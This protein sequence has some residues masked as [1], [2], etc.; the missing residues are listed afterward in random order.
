MQH[1]N[2]VVKNNCH[3]QEPVPQGC[4]AGNISGIYNACRYHKKG[5]SLLNRCVEDPRLQISG[6]TPNWITARGFTLIELLVVVLIMGILAAV[7]VPQYQKA[8]LAARYKNLLATFQPITQSMERYYL[9]SGTYPSSLSQLDVQVPGKMGGGEGTSSDSRNLNGYCINLYPSSGWYW[10][11][12]RKCPGSR[13]ENGYVYIPKQTRRFY[14]VDP[15]LYCFQSYA[16][17]NKHDGGC[18]GRLVNQSTY[19]YFYTLN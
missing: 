11:T 13:G 12:F 2:V 1:R 6:M 18:K 7:A 4:C 5:Q 9:E 17:I 16:G 10:L 8:V 15:G 3:S 14:D 19:G